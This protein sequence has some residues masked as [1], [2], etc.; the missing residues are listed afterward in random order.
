[1]LVTEPGTDINQ[2]WV[3]AAC[4]C[5][6]RAVMPPCAAFAV[7]SLL[8]ET[9]LLLCWR[10]LCSGSQLMRGWVFS[11][12][13]AAPCCG[14]ARVFFLDLALS[15]GRHLGSCCKQHSTGQELGAC[16]HLLRLPRATHTLCACEG[17]GIVV[18]DVLRGLSSSSGCVCE[19]MSRPLNSWGTAKHRPQVCGRCVLA[20]AQGILAML[21]GSTC[22]HALLQ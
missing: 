1:M 16:T 9:G 3:C 7:H 5:A 19:C 4:C 12:Q 17:V 13:A 6:R 11:S 22:S 20:H 14:F 21:L 15:A 18:G 2:H 8:G 10:F